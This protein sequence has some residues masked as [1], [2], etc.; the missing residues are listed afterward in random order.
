MS[1]GDRREDQRP[2][3]LNVQAL[4]EGH[5]HLFYQALGRLLRDEGFDA[6]V[7]EQ[8]RPFYSDKMG[9]PPHL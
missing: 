2:I 8:S 7:E 5:G 9:R 1:M 3:W 6:F 4:S